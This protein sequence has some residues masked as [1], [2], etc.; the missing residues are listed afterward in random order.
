M[1]ESFAEQGLPH[2]AVAVIVAAAMICGVLLVTGHGEYPVFHTILDTSLVLVLG[3][4]ALLVWDMGESAGSW[5]FR[6][7]GI[8]FAVTSIL[9]VIHLVFTVEWSQS[10]SIGTPLRAFPMPN[11]W[12]PST[13]V[14]AI[15]VGWALWRLRSGVTGRMISF[16]AGLALLGAVLFF[17]FQLLPVYLPPVAPAIIGPGLVLAPLLWAVVGVATWQLRAMDRLAKPLI[18]MAAMLCLADIVMLF[19]SGPNEWQSM[20]AHVCRVGGFLV[21]LLS[22]AQMGSHHLRDRI[23]AEA[24]LASLNADLDRR[25]AVRTAELRESETKFRSV[26]ENLS[27]GLMIFDRDGTVL[28]HNPASSRMHGIV[29]EADGF[30]RRAELPT[31]WKGWDKDDVLLPFAAWP[32]AR[33]LN[34]ERFQDQFLHV[35]RADGGVKFDAV[36]N[37]SPIYANNGEMLLGFVTLRDVQDEIRAQ[38]ELAHAHALLRGFADAVPGAIYAKDRDGR[39]LYANR[40]AAEAIGKDSSAFIG[41]TV[42]E[43]TDDKAHAEAVMATDRRIMESGVAEQV[44]EHVTLSNGTSTIWLS[45]KAPMLDAAGRVTGIIG[46]SVDISARK[47]AQRE[48]V[49]ANERLAQQSAELTSTNERLNQALTNSDLLLREVYHR[50]KNNMQIVDSILVMQTSALSDPAAKSAL[51]SL[52]A[53]VCALGL[54]HHQLMGSEDLQTFDVAIFLQELTANILDGGVS[55]NVSIIVSADPLNV[56][57]DFGI[58]LGL[59]VTEL[60]TNSLKHAFPDGEGEV[61]V[62]LQRDTDAT[63]NLVVSDNGT[64]Y[65]VRAATSA[66]KTGGLGSTIITALVGQLK[67][68]MNIRSENGT[69]AEIRLAAPR[70]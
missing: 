65:N 10:L 51:T 39:M 33:V 22:I 35:E 63:L 17:V 66:A 26:V 19:S 54:V 52:R 2:A 58:P 62:V 6:R 23:R 21:L 61:S 14:L 40:G 44:E 37:G 12:R 55:R 29:R 15:G 60:V 24:M 45:T 68:T 8:A 11:A 46:S 31:Q 7:L 36:F 3:V 47:V 9:A 4:M 69:R 28:F 18:A 13:H 34:G 64:G 16:A 41:K 59:L 27:E 42:V 5:F 32:I 20:V 38:R 49:L 50:V 56:G 70:A 67:G 43:F 30:F 53:R 48:L 25:V 57:L 1:H